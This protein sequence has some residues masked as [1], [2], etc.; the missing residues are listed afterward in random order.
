MLS[1]IES[2]AMSEQTNKPQARIA[3]IAFVLLLAYPLSIG[4]I[5]RFRESIPL[6]FKTLSAINAPVIGAWEG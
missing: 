2:E 4:P 3:W 6:N 1:S 5:F